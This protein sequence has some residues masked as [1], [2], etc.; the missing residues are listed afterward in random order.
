MSNLKYLIRLVL[1]IGFIN[2]P[3]ISICYELPKK[4][5]GILSICNMKRHVSL[6]RFTTE[7]SHII[8]KKDMAQH[9]QLNE[10]DLADISIWINKNERTSAVLTSLLN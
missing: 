1:Q 4:Q 3:G 9:F 5:I 8:F 10:S 7:Q 2:D 6:I